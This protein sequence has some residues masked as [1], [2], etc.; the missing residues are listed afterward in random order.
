MITDHLARSAKTS[1]PSDKFAIELTK[2]L[3]LLLYVVDLV[4]CALQIY[5]LDRY[6]Q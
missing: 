4:L 6:R 2:D 1:S 5:D 3:D